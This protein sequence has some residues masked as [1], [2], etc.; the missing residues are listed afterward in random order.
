[1]SS[2]VRM[3]PFDHP[4]LASFSGVGLSAPDHEVG[5]LLEVDSGK[6]VVLPAADRLHPLEAVARA[7]MVVDLEEEGPLLGEED[8]RVVP[9]LD[10]TVAVG[11][12]GPAVDRQEERIAPSSLVLQR[13]VQDAF[14]LVAPGPRPPHH[15]RRVDL[16]ALEAGVEAREHRRPFDRAAVEDG[17][18]P[19][20]GLARRRVL[21]DEGPAVGTEGPVEDVRRVLAREVL[22]RPARAGARVARRAVP[23]PVGEEGEEAV[24]GRQEPRFG[25]PA[26]PLEIDRGRLAARRLHVLQALDGGGEVPRIA[27]VRLDEVEPLRVGS[28]LRG[29]GEDPLPLEEGAGGPAHE[30]VQPQLG[31]DALIELEAQGLGMP[32]QGVMPVGRDLHPLDPVVV[33]GEAGERAALHVHREEAHGGRRRGLDHQRRVLVLRDLLSVKALRLGRD[34][35]DRVRV[36]PVEADDPAV[37]P[38]ERPGLAAVGADDPELGLGQALVLFVVPG[39]LALLAGSRGKRARAQEGDRLPVRRPLRIRV[40]VPAAGERDLLALAPE[41]AQHEVRDLLARVLVH[42]GLHP[43]RPLAVRRDP[44]AAGL[45]G[46]EDVVDGPRLGRRRGSRRGGECGRAGR[47]EGEQHEEG[48]RSMRRP[49][50]LANEAHGHLV[51]NGGVYRTAGGRPAGRLLAHLGTAGDRIPASRRLVLV[52]SAS[53]SRPS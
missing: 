38:G 3:A 25:E 24:E 26:R 13:V 33:L 20:G 39:V 42:P 32:G 4:M 12:G 22:S 44:E 37:E 48:R 8:L 23:H 14:D 52:G 40:A 36:P 41:A 16:L 47:E 10:P 15:L 35:D 17:L 1:M 6:L 7:A 53:S 28:P 19:L 50:G 27:G 2:V 29:G 46:E 31:R 21:V 18:V 43:D 49:A 11:V 9:A 34:N 51:K 5:A 30:V 45:L